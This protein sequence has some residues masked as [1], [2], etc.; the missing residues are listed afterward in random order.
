MTVFRNKIF[1]DHRNA[2]EIMYDSVSE[3]K[4]VMTLVGN[5]TAIAI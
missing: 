3:Q 2:I 1:R 5:R 4:Y